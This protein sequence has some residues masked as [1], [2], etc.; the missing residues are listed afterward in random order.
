MRFRKN[1]ILVFTTLVI[2]AF[3]GVAMGVNLDQGAVLDDITV[4]DISGKDVHLSDYRGKV[5][6]LTF[7]STWC[8]RCLDEL[9]FLNENYG[10]IEELVI[11]AVNQDSDKEI[12]VKR[13]ERFINKIGN[14]TF[15]LVF[16]DGYK[17]WDRF[18]INALPTAIIIDREGRVNYIEPNFYFAS[19]D[20]FRKAI[21][22]LLVASR[23]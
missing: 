23:H 9:T 8:T 14:A 15:K 19:P 20:N 18:G 16:D 2:L 17:L 10:S 11:I 7:W 6:V 12:N 1:A 21:G 13:A 22:N 5:V 3:A 4:Q